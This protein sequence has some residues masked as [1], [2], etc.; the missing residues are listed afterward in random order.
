MKNLMLLS[1]LPLIVG[2]LCLSASHS[3]ADSPFSSDLAALFDD[4][5]PT[6]VPTGDT[7]R[8]ARFRG[9]QPMAR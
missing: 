7:P 1:G 4:L 2:G 8:R 9:A 5:D 3:I 6:D